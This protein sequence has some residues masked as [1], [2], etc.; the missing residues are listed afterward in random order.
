M[1][2]KN[3]S[4]WEVN[5]DKIR[6]FLISASIGIFS[7]LSFVCLIA[8]GLISGDQGYRLLEVVFG[9]V[10][11]PTVFEPNYFL[12]VAF[13]L[14]VIAFVSSMRPNIKPFFFLINGIIFAVSALLL[15][16]IVPLNDFIQDV[17]IIPVSIG[18]GTIIAA[19]ILIISAVAA[20]TLF[21]YETK[22]TRSKVIN[23]G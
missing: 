18:Y 15:F 16:L 7:M 10:G 12:I 8:P 4:F 23:N 22:G 9:G 6:A 19:I 2:Q 3:P 21:V 17:P 20:I 5:K 1:E 11:E 13:I 14:I